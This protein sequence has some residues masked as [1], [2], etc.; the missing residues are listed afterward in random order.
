[1]KLIVLLIAFVL[2]IPLA[3]ANVMGLVQYGGSEQTSN[4]AGATE[5]C[6]PYVAFRN[7]ESRNGDV[8]TYGGEMS[9]VPDYGL[10]YVK[11]DPAGVA[12]D[13]AKAS[14]VGQ[15]SDCGLPAHRVSNDDISAGD[16]WVPASDEPP[17]FH[18]FGTDQTAWLAAVNKELK[19]SGSRGILVVGH[20]FHNIPEGVATYSAHLRLETG[21]VVVPAFWPTPME[22]DQ[23]L[24]SELIVTWAAKPFNDHL[25]Q[26]VLQEIK[27]RGYEIDFL[28]HSQ[29]NHFVQDVLTRLSVSLAAARRPMR[30]FNKI[31]LSSPDVDRKAFEH[32]GFDVKDLSR[33]VIVLMSGVDKPLELSKQVH[34]GKLWRLGQ[35]V[36]D[37]LPPVVTNVSWVDFT[38]PDE[39]MRRPMG[40]N[41]I[42]WLIADLLKGKL[43]APWSLIV[44]RQGDSPVLKIV[45]QSSQA[46]H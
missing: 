46:L 25:L 24:T 38:L 44:E 29:G 43:R 22:Y 20:G 33:E 23:Y 9:D 30:V 12:G 5:V 10:A 2:L 14:Q 34:G 32:W 17:V 4:Q 36:P 1:M 42:P 18:S 31:I 41:L 39:S 13:G 16:C 7:V 8:V 45:Q 40:H 27:P 15:K 3:Q 37:E 21:L 11:V 35:I 6:V 26:P 19:I 28:A